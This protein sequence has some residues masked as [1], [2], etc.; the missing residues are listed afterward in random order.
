MTTVPSTFP[1]RSPKD[2]PPLLRVHGHGELGIAV[3]RGAGHAL[4]TLCGELDLAGAPRVRA[5]LRDC[6]G[7]GE[8]ITVD[9][10]NLRFLDCSGLRPLVEAADLGVRRGRRFTI[11]AASVP[12]RRVLEL[13]RLTR[14]L[15]AS[16]AA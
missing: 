15:D 3:R 4:V 6:A 12:V 13:T 10:R 5:V 14:L 11:G 16:P 1:T 2:V 7:R 8:D 9:L